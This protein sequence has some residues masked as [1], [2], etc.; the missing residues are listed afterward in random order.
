MLDQ[1]TLSGATGTRHEDILTFAKCLKDT[2]L[3]GTQGYRVH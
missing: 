2:R 1:F 3:F